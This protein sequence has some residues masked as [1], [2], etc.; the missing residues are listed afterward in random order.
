MDSIPI[1]L[2]IEGV[3]HTVIDGQSSFVNHKRKYL[4]IDIFEGMMMGIRYSKN[5]KIYQLQL[6][7]HH[8]DT[9]LLY[10]FTYIHDKDFVSFADFMN[11]FENKVNDHM[12]SFCLQC[13]KRRKVLHG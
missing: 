2:E 7:P 8:L 13:G 6:S 1:K 11:G 12:A 9:K 5:I 4:R 3:V 10:D